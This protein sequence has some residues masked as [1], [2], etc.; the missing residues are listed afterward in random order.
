M[1]PNSIGVTRS[2]T[3][4]GGKG[5]LEEGIAPK[6]VE[7]DF[8]KMRMEEYTK[9]GKEFYDASGALSKRVLSEEE[10]GKLIEAEIAS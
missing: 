8:V 9:K 4:Y 7:D 6:F 10:A 5:N 2:I 1:I 3:E